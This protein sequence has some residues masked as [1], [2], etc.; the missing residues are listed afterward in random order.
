M[1]D[2]NKLKDNWEDKQS[3]YHLSKDE[4][5]KIILLRFYESM[6]GKKVVFLDLN[7]W[8]KFRDGKTPY[9]G[10]Y[11]KLKS[12]AEGQQIVCVLS[13][14][15]IDEMEK[16]PLDKRLETA[17]VMDGLQC[18]AVL[19]NIQICTNERMNLD[20]ALS[21]KVLTKDYQFSPIFESNPFL[22]NA[23]L[24]KHQTEE[25]FIYNT[26]YEDLF[27]MP[28]EEYCKQTNSRHF[29]SSERFAYSFNQVKKSGID[30]QSYKEELADGLQSQIAACAELINYDFTSVIDLKNPVSLFIKHAPYIYLLSAINAAIAVDRDRAFKG[31]D[32]FDTQHSC[33]AIGY[34]DFFFTERKFHHLL[35]SKPI[36]AASHFRIKI[37]SAPDKILNLLNELS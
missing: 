8:L 12:L 20:H 2:L 26:L 30:I 18:K 37:E 16:M 17:R 23:V 27:V 5:K 29:D 36:D 34:A 31:N 1:Y 22:S 3:I 19:N 6:K 14:S 4:F 33:A 24:K 21:G 35:H 15:I 25:V 7:F 9:T 11:D 32:F 28:V 10:I 13:S